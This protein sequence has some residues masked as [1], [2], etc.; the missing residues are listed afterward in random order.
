MFDEHIIIIALLIII[1]IWLSYLTFREPEIPVQ[2]LSVEGF[3]LSQ[4]ALSNIAAIYQKKKLYVDNVIVKDKVIIGDED[5]GMNVKD[6]I[7][8]NKTSINSNRNTFNSARTSLQ[9][10]INTKQPN[11]DYVKY[12]DEIKINNKYKTWGSY[13]DT[14]GSDGRCGQSAWGVY[15]HRGGIRHPETSV[16]RILK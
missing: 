11:G 13:L 4:E 1:I 16:W 2:I 14:C 7:N 9:A 10:Q 6:T 12:N 5:T 8:S 3:E 15:S